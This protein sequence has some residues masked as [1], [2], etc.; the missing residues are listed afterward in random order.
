MESVVRPRLNDCHGI[1]LL[2]DK[3]DFAIPFLDEDIPLYVDPFLMWK[4]PSQMDNGLH[5][6]IIQN[7]NQLGHLVSHGKEKEATELLIGLSECEAVGLG[8]S[9]TRKG[10][11]IGEKVANDILRLFCDIPQLKTNGF[12]HIEEVQ[13]LVGQI[14]KDRISDITCNLISSF[15]IDYTIQRCEEHKIPMEQVTIESV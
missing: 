14:A 4:S 12:T 1:L 10:N 6:S 11:R 13:L 5:D 15:L 8:T 9:K 3:V 2:Q 7:F